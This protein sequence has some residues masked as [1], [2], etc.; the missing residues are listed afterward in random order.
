M[1]YLYTPG[2]I[3]VFRRRERAPPRG[4]LPQAVAEVLAG[5]TAVA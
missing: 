1:P 3:V 2:E 5:Y 4:R